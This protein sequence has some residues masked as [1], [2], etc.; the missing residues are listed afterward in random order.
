MIKV[1]ILVDGQE[2]GQASV[3]ETKWK[4]INYV[5]YIEVDSKGRLSGDY[6]GH[7]IL[8]QIAMENLAHSVL[9]N[10]ANA[11]PRSL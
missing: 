6:Q 2:V 1:A 5:D 10:A 9:L 11:F 7:G 8:A 3:S 4:L